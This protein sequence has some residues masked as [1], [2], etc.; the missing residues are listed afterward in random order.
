M[1]A[2][3]NWNPPNPSHT[4]SHTH[5]HTHKRTMS[6]P[7]HYPPSHAEPCDECCTGVRPQ[8]FH[9]RLKA[10]A[11]AIKYHLLSKAANSTNLIANADE[12]LELFRG[13]RR[14][15]L[16]ATIDS[17]FQR[18]SRLRRERYGKGLGFRV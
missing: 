8:Y 6:P 14:W 18:S 1:A 17:A 9:A 10:T 3:H 4:H 5:T 13:E 16:G 15:D 2:E 11:T 12:A 7:T